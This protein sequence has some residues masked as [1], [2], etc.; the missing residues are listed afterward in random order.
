MLSVFFQALNVFNTKMALQVL[1]TLSNDK[2]DRVD[3]SIFIAPDGKP[4]R[5]KIEQA[6]ALHVGDRWKLQDWETLDLED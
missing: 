3:V 6:I 2:G 5:P 1:A 4:C